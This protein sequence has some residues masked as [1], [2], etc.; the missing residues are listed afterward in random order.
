MPAAN[1]LRTYDD[2]YLECRRGNLGHVWRVLG[3]YRAPDSE[4][5]RNLICSRCGTQR[6]DRWGAK[7]GE[8]FTPRYKHADGYLISD[9]SGEAVHADDV[10]KEA[11]RRAQVFANEEQMLL[12]LTGASSGGGCKR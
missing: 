12:T 10:R 11:M 4:I 7:S 3:Y 2:E 9:G 5:H 6:L 1:P 8:R